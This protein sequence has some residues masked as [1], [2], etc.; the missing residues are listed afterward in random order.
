MLMARL[1]LVDEGSITLFLVGG[2]NDLRSLREGLGAGDKLRFRVMLREALG[3]P[4]D[5]AND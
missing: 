5:H 3:A 1:P 4:N 2:V